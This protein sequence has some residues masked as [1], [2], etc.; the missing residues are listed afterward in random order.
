MPNDAL[1]HWERVLSSAA[2][3]QRILPEA[4]L[5][6]GTA[7]ALHAEHRKSSDADHVLSDL[8][9]RFDEVLADL[10]IDHFGCVRILISP[11]WWDVK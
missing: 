1:P 7:S 6:G 5:V 11:L 9:Q 8:R 3:L 2:R 10:E 4:A